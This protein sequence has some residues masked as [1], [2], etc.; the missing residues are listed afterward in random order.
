MF[1]LTEIVLQ[2]AIATGIKSIKNNI[3]ILDDIFAQLSHNRLYQPY[4]QT[5]INEIKSWFASTKIPVVQDWSFD[6][7]QIPCISIHLGNE[8]DDESKAA[9]GDYFGNDENSEVIVN[10]MTVMLDIG[11]HADKSKDH[12]LWIYYIVNY[13]L[14]KEKPMLREMGLQLITF[15]ASEYNKEAKYMSENIWTRWIRFR[16]TVQ[17]YIDG[18]IFNE[19][20]DVESEVDFE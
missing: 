4:G 17:N 5:Y 18:D 20:T 13:I 3:S 10:P 11:I 9:I 14:Y 7:T 16:C 1:I 6:V 8:V 15:N 19:I 12:V 2:R